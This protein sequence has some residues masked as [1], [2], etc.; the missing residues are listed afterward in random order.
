MPR[1][2]PFVSCKYNLALDNAKIKEEILSTKSKRKKCILDS[3]PETFALDVAEK[4][5][6]T[7]NELGEMFGIG[8]VIFS[9]II[10]KALFKIAMSSREK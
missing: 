6:I 1:P 2:C 10:S 8:P 3:I 4:R 7:L 9:K 5:G